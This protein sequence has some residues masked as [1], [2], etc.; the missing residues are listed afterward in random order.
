VADNVY[1]QSNEAEGNRVLA[2]RRDPDGTLTHRGSFSTG[3]AGTGAPHLPSQGSVV[4]TGDG[5][6]LLVTNAGSGDLSVFATGDDALTL[7]Q[8]I[9]SGGGAPR[10]VTEHDGLVYVLNTQGPSLSGFRIHDGSL[11]PVNSAERNHHGTRS[12]RRYDGVGRVRRRHED[13]LS[14]NGGLFA[15]HGAI[16]L[17]QVRRVA[18][19]EPLLLRGG[20]D[21]AAIRRTFTTMQQMIRGGRMGEAIMFSIQESIDREVRRGHMSSWVG[22]AMR[23]FPSSV[24]AGLIDLFLRH[25]R[26]RS[27]N[28]A[29]RELVASLPAELDPVLDTE[30]TLEQYRQLDARV[31][32]MYGSETDPMFVDCA[33]ALHAVLPHST[34]LRLPGLNHDSAQTYGKPETIAAALRLFFAQRTT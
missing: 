26:P 31:L 2:F 18:A 15:L 29:W 6:H 3:G 19:Y 21:D 13:R 33:E 5:R 23:A 25:V 24:G 28:V 17:G 22:G 11:E 16:G 9:P 12:R 34:V 27:G 14:A 30:G 1:I 32:L 10:S 4:L 8:P 7:L 20:P